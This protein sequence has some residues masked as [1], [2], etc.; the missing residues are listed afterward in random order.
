MLALIFAVNGVAKAEGINYTLQGGSTGANHFTFA[1]LTM[2]GLQN[3]L[4]LDLVV[5][6]KVD[7]VG[8]ATVKYVDGNLVLEFF[9]L[10]KQLG[11]RDFVKDFMKFNFGAV[12]FTIMDAP[13]NGNIHSMKE[14]D[15][16]KKLGAQTGFAHDNKYTIPCPSVTCET[17]PI[18]LYIHFDN[19]TFDLGTEE[20]AVEWKVT[21]PWHKVSEEVI[22]TNSVDSSVEVSWVVYFSDEEGTL[23]EEFMG[24]LD[25]M[26]SGYY[27]VVF[28]DEKD[29]G[30]N[31]LVQVL[32]NDT[33]EAKYFAEYSE[34]AGP[35]IIRKGRTIHNEL[36]IINKTVVVK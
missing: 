13:N 26:D 9:P 10:D 28:T 8:K 7:V 30:E 22:N 19:V 12:A 31:V 6:N 5:G 27:A 3:G 24:D 18:Y 15:L 2:A 35:T 20:S 11:E 1:T 23:G 17:T 32:A 16:I 25:K 14:A 36:V 21:T 33:V 34:D 29:G 4:E